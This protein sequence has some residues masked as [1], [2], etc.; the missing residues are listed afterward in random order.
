LQTFAARIPA[1]SCP[2]CVA[3]FVPTTVVQVGWS[4][5]GIFGQQA[6]SAAHESS[7]GTAV[8][9]GAGAAPPACPCGAH[10]VPQLWRMHVL[11]AMLACEHAGVFEDMA[12]SS[13]LRP[14][15]TH[16][17]SSGHAGPT[18]F[19]WSEQLDDMHVLHASLVG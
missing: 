17:T 13:M 7:P 11:N 18:A 15:H 4:A 19:I 9:A 5:A 6:V 3:F 12:Q 2:H 1:R 16:L 14:L 8:T 10:A